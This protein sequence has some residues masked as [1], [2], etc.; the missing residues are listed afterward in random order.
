MPCRGHGTFAALKNTDSSTIPRQRDLYLAAWIECELA[1]RWLVAKLRLRPQMKA[2][3]EL[4]KSG[5]IP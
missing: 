3:F 4:L 2:S 5:P 1:P